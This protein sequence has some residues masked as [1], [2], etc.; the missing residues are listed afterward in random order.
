[1]IQSKDLAGITTTMVTALK[2][3]FGT[4]CVMAEASISSP[5][6]V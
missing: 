5:M 3:C 1:M 2:E 4:E 6:A